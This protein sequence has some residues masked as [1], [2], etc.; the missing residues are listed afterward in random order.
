MS[1][2]YRR[3]SFGQPIGP[4]LSGWQERALPPR[5]PMIGRTCRVA[6][7]DVSAHADGLF[8]VISEDLTGESW[9]YLASE[10]V[11]GRAAYRDYLAHVFTSP[12][13][14]CHTILDGDSGRP[15]GI[16]SLMRIDPRNGVIEIG[17]IHYA[18]RLQRTVAATEAMFLLMRRVFDELGYRRYEWKCDSLNAPSRAAALRYGYSFEGIFRQAVVTK[19]RSR[20]TAWYAIVDRDWPAL[21]SAYEAWLEPGNFDAAGGQRRRLGDLIAAAR[22]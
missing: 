9:T 17:H 15:L 12:D 8:D 19:G 21:K 3:N 4:A 2:D 14:M 10:P 18:P 16:A 11:G 5:T 1:E 7:L 22:R 6:P 13:P 20:D